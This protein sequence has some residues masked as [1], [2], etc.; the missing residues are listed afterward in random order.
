MDHLIELAKDAPILT[1]QTVI[2]VGMGLAGVW[3][4]W[5]NRGRSQAQLKAEQKRIRRERFD[6]A[7]RQYHEEQQRFRH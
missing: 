6:A 4:V 3:Q 5:R 2:L 7:L 1:F